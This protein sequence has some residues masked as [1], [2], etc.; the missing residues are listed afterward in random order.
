M[1]RLKITNKAREDL[2]GIA[3][4]TEVTWGREQRKLYLGQL[5]TLFQALAENPEL[6]H[7]CDE[8]KTGYY[9]KQEGSHIVFYRFS[10]LDGVVIVRVLHKRMD[11]S[12]N[13]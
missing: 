2:V 12:R 8:I 7:S 5:D 6:G 4:Y 1:A 11:V 3:R 13:L 9:K 10:D